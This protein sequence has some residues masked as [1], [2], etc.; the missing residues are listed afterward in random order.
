MYEVIKFEINKK[1]YFKLSIHDLSCIKL[2][3]SV[4]TLTE[5]LLLYYFYQKLAKKVF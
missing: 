2:N 1:R 4:L 5:T 3:K